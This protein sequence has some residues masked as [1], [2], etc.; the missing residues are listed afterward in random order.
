M[1]LSLT[2]YTSWALKKPSVLGCLGDSVVEHLPLAQVMIPGS[3]G[4]VP[5]WASCVEPASPSACVS[6]FLYV[7]L[8]NE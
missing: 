8:M 1:A 6:A 5:P 7:P 3:C 2:L 4:Q